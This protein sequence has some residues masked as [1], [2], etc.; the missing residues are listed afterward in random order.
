MFVRLRVQ[1]LVVCHQIQPE[2]IWTALNPQNHLA[3]KLAASASWAK[4]PGFRGSAERQRLWMWLGRPMDT[5]SFVQGVRWCKHPH[6]N[7]HRMGGLVPHIKGIYWYFSG[8]KLRCQ[9]G[10]GSWARHFVAT[11]WELHF[12]RFQCFGSW[13]IF[14][15]RQSVCSKGI[16]L[17]EDSMLKPNLI[18]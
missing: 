13:R 10:V 5:P 14:K 11:A 8:F 1:I 3:S 7:F 16:C 4:R 18:F 2:R 17:S 6:S 15:N 12:A 9:N